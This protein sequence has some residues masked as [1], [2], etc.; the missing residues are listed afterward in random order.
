[1]NGWP[2]TPVRHLS[3]VDRATVRRIYRRLRQAGVRRTLAVAAVNGL[4]HV[5][6]R[7][8]ID[9]GVVFDPTTWTVRPKAGA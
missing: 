4:L 1:M 3:S 5:G 8:A 7:F 2:T 6:L 9:Q